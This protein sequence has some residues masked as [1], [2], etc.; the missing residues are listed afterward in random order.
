MSLKGDG[1]AQKLDE[2]QKKVLENALAIKVYIYIY[3][4]NNN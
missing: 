2:M 4:W 3:W 1:V